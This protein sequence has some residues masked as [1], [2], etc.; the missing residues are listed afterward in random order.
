[1]DDFAIAIDDIKK[2]VY[3]RKLKSVD[4]KNTELKDEIVKEEI[5]ELKK[6]SDK[7]ILVGSPSLIVALANLDLVDEFQLGVQPTVVGSGLPLF[8][9]VT[10]RIDLRL[11]K[12][13]PFDCGA[14]VLC[15]EPTTRQA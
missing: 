11:V 10:G 8:R 6:T 12:R 5:L 7:D 13:R 15:Y 1:M 2:I 3:S 14:I 4:W 9:N